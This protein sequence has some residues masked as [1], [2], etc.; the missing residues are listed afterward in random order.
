MPARPYAKEGAQIRP[1]SSGFLEYVLLRAGAVNRR[2]LFDKP[3]GAKP[4]GRSGDVSGQQVRRR[5]ICAGRIES[6]TC[7]F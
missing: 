6:A 4:G 1:P 7:T 5:P 3:L 2:S